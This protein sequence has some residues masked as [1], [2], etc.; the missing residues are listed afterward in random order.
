[1]TADCTAHPADLVSQAHSMAY[2]LATVLAEAR[3]QATLGALDM[4]GLAAILGMI[5]ERLKVALIKL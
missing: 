4:E 2:F 1:M 3:E 5:E